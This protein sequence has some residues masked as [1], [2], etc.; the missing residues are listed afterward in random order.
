MGFDYVPSVQVLWGNS[1]G[2]RERAVSALQHVRNMTTVHDKAGISTF[3]H[4]RSYTFEYPWRVSN[5]LTTIDNAFPEFV[6]II[7]TL[8]ISNVPK[9]NN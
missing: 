1:T 7:N 9:Q 8:N 5:A 3:P 6:N 4:R 2:G